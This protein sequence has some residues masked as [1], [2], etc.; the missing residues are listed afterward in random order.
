MLQ[1]TTPVCQS[2]GILQILCVRELCCGRCNVVIRICVSDKGTKHPCVKA[3][4]HNVCVW[5][6]ENPPAIVEHVRDSPKV[7]FL[8]RS[9]SFIEMYRLF[10]WGN[11]SWSYQLLWHDQAVV[12]VTD[13]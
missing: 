12:I 8:A 13:T 1:Y 10:F 11:R 7:T 4:M 6:S 3:N 2:G 9:R 5:G